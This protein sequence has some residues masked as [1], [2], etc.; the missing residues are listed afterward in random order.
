[1]GN[2]RAD[3]E[4]YVKP[5]GPDSTFGPGNN[6][7]NATARHNFE[8]GVASPSSPYHIIPTGD[9]TSVQARQDALKS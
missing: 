2:I 7:F 1:M 5:A 4:G 9:A 6:P 8:G 3:Q